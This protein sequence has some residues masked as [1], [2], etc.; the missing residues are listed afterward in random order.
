MTMSSYWT[1]N[2]HFLTRRGTGRALAVS[3]LAVFFC[4]CNAFN[5]SFVALFQSP[6]SVSNETLPNAPGHVVVA[7]NNQTEIDERLLRYLTSL[8]VDAKTMRPRIRLRVRITYVDQSF[9]VW[10]FV[11]GSGDLIDPAFIAQA[12]PDLNQTELNNTVAVCNVA[13]VELEPGTNVEVFLPVKIIQYQLVQT[14][15]QGGQTVTT[16]QQR[17]FITP[18]FWPLQID[19]VNDTGITLQRNIG[20][21][22]VLSPVPNVICGSI[23]VITVKGALAVP[24]L[25]PVSADVP[26]VDQD[27]LATVSRIA[28]RYEFVVT[29]Q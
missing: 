24:F 22:D 18:K 11:S 16:F 17:G 1:S 3:V 6:N 15:N 7:V 2:F 4:G 20:V 9:I 23:V 8:G 28:G 25:D 10:E 27:D 12:D 29:V 5:P 21:R 14:N 13:R 26:S 19:T